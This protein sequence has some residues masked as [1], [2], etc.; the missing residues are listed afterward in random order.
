MK[1]SDRLRPLARR[2]MIPYARVLKPRFA[3]RA[4][5]KKES[6]KKELDEYTERTQE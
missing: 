1:K 2:P 5:E 6:W 4:K 3:R